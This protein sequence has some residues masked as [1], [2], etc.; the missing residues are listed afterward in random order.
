MERFTGFLVFK[1]L[2]L[3]PKLILPLLDNMKV[4][5]LSLNTLGEFIL[6]HPTL[7]FSDNVGLK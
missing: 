2:I 6:N 7:G 5:L 4:L 1:G 3:N